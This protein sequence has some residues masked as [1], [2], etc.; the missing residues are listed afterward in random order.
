M[1]I[2]VCTCAG[3]FAHI[4]SAPLKDAWQT[5][6]YQFIRF[7]LK[8]AVR[9]LHEPDQDSHSCLQLLGTKEE[10]AIARDGDDPLVCGKAP[11]Q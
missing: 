3:D 5:Y 1:S 10:A 2:D 7:L 9:G 4:M 6:R 11:P 8:L